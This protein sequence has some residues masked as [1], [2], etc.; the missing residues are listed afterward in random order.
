MSRVFRLLARLGPPTLETLPQ[1]FKQQGVCAAG[2]LA[3]QLQPAVHIPLACAVQHAPITLRQSLATV[4][5]RSDPDE[6][7][8]WEYSMMLA[9]AGNTLIP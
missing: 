3:A 4:A 6:I 5:S 9:V 2:S 8:R 7:Y 1:A